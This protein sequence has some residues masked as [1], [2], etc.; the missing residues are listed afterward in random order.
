MGRKHARFESAQSMLSVN[1]C[2]MRI[3][4]ANSESGSDAESSRQTIVPSGKPWRYTL[5]LHGQVQHECDA[6]R[7]GEAIWAESCKFHFVKPLH[8]I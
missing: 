5:T 2:L 7:S 3:C 1:N 8:C 6:G 4:P